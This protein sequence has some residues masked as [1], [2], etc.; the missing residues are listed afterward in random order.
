MFGVH[1]NIVVHVQVGV[2]V[3]V[4]VDQLAGVGPDC[5]LAGGGCDAKLRSGDASSLSVFLIFRFCHHWRLSG[6]GTRNSSP[7]FFPSDARLLQAETTGAACLAFRLR[8]SSRLPG[9]C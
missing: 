9:E 4:Y 2:G 8:S 6:L 3:G 5:Q 7:N 1:V